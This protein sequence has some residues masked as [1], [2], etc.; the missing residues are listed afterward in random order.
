MVQTVLLTPAAIACDI[1]TALLMRAKLYQ[2]AHSNKFE[3]VL[4]Y[5]SMDVGAERLLNGLQIGPCG[6]RWS[7]ASDGRD[8]GRIVHVLHGGGFAIPR[9][10]TGR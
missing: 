8:E 6:R 7:A 3:M 2:T 4:L 5:G 9:S 1:F 10:S